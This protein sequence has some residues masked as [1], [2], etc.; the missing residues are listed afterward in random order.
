VE[1]A[2]NL[3]QE[4]ASFGATHLMSAAPMGTVKAH[5]TERNPSEKVKTIIKNRESMRYDRE[6]RLASR[7]QAMAA[8]EGVR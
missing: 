8:G 5:D 3:T 7:W 4:V 1:F 2:H 6:T